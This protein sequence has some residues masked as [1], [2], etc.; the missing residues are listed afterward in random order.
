[1]H[2]SI[3]LTGVLATLAIAPASAQVLAFTDFTGGT[4]GWQGNGGAVVQNSNGNDIFRIPGVTDMFWFEFWNDSNPDWIGNYGAKGDLLEFSVDVQTNFIRV[5]QQTVT[6]RAVILE[7]RNYDLGDDFYPYASVLFEMGRV[8]GFAQD[9]TTF[10]VTFDPNAQALPDGWRA[11][12]SED[13]QGNWTLPP[14]VTF[15]DLLSGVDEIL[16]HSAELGV[17]YPFTRFDLMIDNVTLRNV[18]APGSLALLGLAGL[19]SR[20]RRA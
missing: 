14:G 20:R 13:D 9:W 4:D 17:F 1:M 3:M 10:S 8:S 6:D 11:Y 7:L 15:A 19:A 2:R 5:G 18:P 12:G 16:I